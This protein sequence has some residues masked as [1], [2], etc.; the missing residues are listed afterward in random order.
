MRYIFTAAILIAAIISTAFFCPQSVTVTG[1]VTDV[2]GTPLT[3]VSIIERGKQNGTSTDQKGT[4]S[5]VV[6]N[7]N[8]SLRFSYVGY[9]TTEVQLKG[10]NS[11][12]VSM[13]LSTKQMDEV[14]VVGYAIQKKISVTGS[15]ALAQ[16]K[17]YGS[18]VSNFSP[19][20]GYFEKEENF[21]TEDYDGITEN[22]FRKVTDEPLSTFSID[23][24]AA[25]Y[26]NVRRMINYGQMPP[27]GAVRIEEFINYFKYNYPQP[28][29]ND[30]FS[31]N[32]EMSVCPWNKQHKLVMIGLQ[33]KQI[34][35]ENLPPSN[36]VFLID[37]SGSMDEPNK[38]PLVKASLKLLVNQL[39]E[40]DNVAI[41]VYAGA[42]GLV[43]P[44]TSGAHKEKIL[45]AIE[46]LNA[47]GSTAGGAGIQLAYKTAK[48]YFKKGGNNRVI[49]CTDGDF[50]V[51]MSSDDAM[52]RLIEEERKSGVFLTVLGY[53]MGNYKDNKMQKLADKGNGN[54]AYIDGMNE[55]KKV[56]VSEFG[57]TMFTIAK[58]VKLQIEFNPLLVQ[59]YRLVG[60]ENRM[61]NK[62]DFNNDKKDAGELGSG[63]TVTALYEIIPAGVESEFVDDVDDLKYQQVKTNK[64]SDLKNEIMTIK[65]RY[66][67]PD[68]EVSKLIVHP[69]TD[70]KIPFDKTSE[71]FRFAGAVAQF[72]MLLRN[73]E[74]K[75]GATYEKVIRQAT[76]ALGKDEEGYRAEFVKMAQTVS[77][78]V[79]KDK[80]QESSVVIEE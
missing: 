7:Q 6:S 63:H 41:V 4:F 49:L 47:G 30:P 77:A 75:A 59:A 10:K 57:S 26:S 21:N 5:L 17:I 8:A 20:P 15:V 38:L 9:E 53:G 66:K 13:K 27:A 22:R 1:V 51:G 39:R 56:L 40:Q 46:Q 74:F 69:V 70:E 36:L 73:S 32:T 31:I 42:A 11:I 37:V 52:E 61:L 33:G 68:G 29:N 2:N 64:K 48:D 24:D 60:Y 28:T 58:D 50:N 19:S 71:N 67:E 65:F 23:V 3:G 34:A 45:A 78:L 62:E 25:S 79:K 14:V 35:T 76:G 12:N 80:Q 16:D 44:S 54:H 72:G 55:A 18:R 43:L